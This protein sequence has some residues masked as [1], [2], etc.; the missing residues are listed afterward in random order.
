MCAKVASNQ[1]HRQETP[2]ANITIDEGARGIAMGA[3]P[4][5]IKKL[6]I[7]LM[8][9]VEEEEKMG[10]GSLPVLLDMA[11]VKLARHSSGGGVT[12]GTPM[13]LENVTRVNQAG[14]LLDRMAVSPRY[15]TIIHSP[16]QSPAQTTDLDPDDT[17]PPA[18]VAIS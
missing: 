18:K 13:K 16:G 2:H 10:H 4:E 3:A 15:V 12:L 17:V 14:L 5:L 7:I 1:G 6:D 8:A 9:V 11:W